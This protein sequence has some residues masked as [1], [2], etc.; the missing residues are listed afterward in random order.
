[1]HRILS[2]H[3]ILVASLLASSALAAAA[4]T[5]Q[6]ANNAVSS[7]PVQVTTGVTSPKLESAAVVQ[8]NSDGSLDSS[9]NPATMLLHVRLDNTGAVTQIQVVRPIS[10]DVDTQVIS[11]VRQFHWKPAMLD[12]RA[13]P[14]EVNLAVEVQH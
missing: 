7:T 8:I 4:A 2:M 10:P 9:L 13:I 5:P 1:M 14:D 6:P 11:A 3:R 12:G